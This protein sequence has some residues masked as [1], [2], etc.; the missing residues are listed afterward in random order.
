MRDF[1]EFLRQ[2]PLTVLAAVGLA[3]G[4]ALWSLDRP[5]AL[6]VTALVVIG[7]VVVSTAV[8]MVRDLL[9]GHWGRDILAVTAL[10][11]TLAVE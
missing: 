11:A 4:V 8:G 10:L 6:M 5:T 7:T 3:M 1:A 9:S 2:R